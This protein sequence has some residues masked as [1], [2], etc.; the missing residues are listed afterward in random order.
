MPYVYNHYI[1][2][3]FKAV[4][5]W[6]RDRYIDKKNPES[7]NGLTQTQTQLILTNYKSN[8]IEEEMEPEKLDI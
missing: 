1:A 2:T 6:Q 8:P 3:L 7:R 5:Y 4:W